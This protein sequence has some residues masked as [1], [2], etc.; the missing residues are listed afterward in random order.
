MKHNFDG[1]E[2]DFSYPPVLYARVVN[3]VVEEHRTYNFPG[4]TH[5]G[6]R[7]ILPHNYAGTHTARECVIL[8]EP[9]VMLPAPLCRIEGIKRFD[10]PKR[11]VEPD[12]ILQRYRLQ[13]REFFRQ[14]GKDNG[15]LL[16]MAMGIR[17]AALFKDFFV[18][19]EGRSFALSLGP[20]ITGYLMR[21]DIDGLEFEGCKV[22]VL[23]HAHPDTILC[24]PN[25]PARRD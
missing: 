14:G 3:N 9:A 25:D 8:F 22:R 21:H 1:Y 4:A 20:N 12:W 19:G 18:N 17:A 2:I 11:H 5:E 13:R 16:Y 23:D 24:L 6:H 15:R 10:I 7:G